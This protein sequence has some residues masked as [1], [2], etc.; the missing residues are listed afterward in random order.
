MQT[1]CFLFYETLTNTL[2]L[3]Q[4]RLTHNAKHTQ[5]SPITTTTTTAKY[6]W[7]KRVNQPHEQTKH[8]KL[9]NSINNTHIKIVK[10]KHT[11]DNRR[12]LTGGKHLRW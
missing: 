1:F 9:K 4:R 7:Q 2:F 12:Y 10:K 3:W 8:N 11:V 6:H 5:S